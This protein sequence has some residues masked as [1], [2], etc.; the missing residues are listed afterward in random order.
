MTLKSID[1]YEL[2]IQ[3]L[4]QLLDTEKKI[5][6][7]F[8]KLSLKADTEELRSALSTAA[9][10]SEQHIDRISQ[11]LK[12]NQAKASKG[13]NEWNEFLLT[14][15]GKATKASPKPS[16]HQDIEILRSCQYVFMA[17]SVAFQNA[18]Q[19]SKLLE[20]EAAAML[21]E[22]SAKDYQNNYAY[23]VQVAGNIIYPKTN[24]H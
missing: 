23:L 13:A 1:L 7:S 16:I 20:Q 9:K 18:H 4:S 14:A 10:D 2:Y 19:I 15:I 12:L 8:A 21:M 24:Q 3:Q 11:C 17:N 5:S 6:K 22:Q